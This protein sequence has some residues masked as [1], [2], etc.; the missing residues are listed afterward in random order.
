MDIGFS[1][2]NPNVLRPSQAIALGAGP[3]STGSFPV[4][5]ANSTQV[6]GNPS[7]DSPVIIINNNNG[8]G[9]GG[10]TSGPIS[11]QI[12]QS[13]PVSMYQPNGSIP[14]S[15]QPIPISSGPSPTPISQIPQIPQISPQISPQLIPQSSPLGL[16]QSMGSGDPL[17]GIT[18]LLGSLNSL[19][20][21]LT[22]IVSQFGSLLQ[23][24]MGGGGQSPLTNPTISQFPGS[25]PQTPFPGTSMPISM[26]G[27][28]QGFGGFPQGMSGIPQSFG[29][30]P[31]GMGSFPQGFGGIPQSLGGF[32]QG[33]GGT[34][35]GFGGFPQGMSGFPQ[36]QF[37]GIIPMSGQSP[38]PTGAQQPFFQPRP[39]QNLD[40]FAITPQGGTNQLLSNP[41]QQQGT[42]LSP[43]GGISNFLSNP[44]ETRSFTNNPNGSGNGFINN[45]FGTAAF[46]NNGFGNF[47]QFLSGPFGMVNAQITNNGFN[48]T[49]VS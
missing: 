9:G 49:K 35:Q 20:S 32:P 6:Y 25:F 21:N 19:V 34:P 2:G 48:L 18:N 10:S 11:Y 47:N 42:I 16:P 3:A 40:S 33:F 41:F 13:V 5:P 30:F 17:S 12:P 31:Q 8:G 39:F 29:G 4:G 46:T 38:F 15:G 1:M 44:F 23:G 28:P 24:F 37:P 26:G 7:S 43:T 22:G 27:I 45:V 36:S 14:F